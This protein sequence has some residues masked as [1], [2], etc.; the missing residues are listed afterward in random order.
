MGNNRNMKIYKNMKLKINNGK[1]TKS[2]IIFNKKYL[3]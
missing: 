2:M 1:H 3:I